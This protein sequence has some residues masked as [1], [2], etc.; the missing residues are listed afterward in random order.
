MSEHFVITADHG[1]LRIFQ[2][3]EAP[4]QSTAAL[5]EIQAE[6]FPA[7][8]RGYVQRDTDM[9]G[10]FQSSAHQGRGPGAPTARQGMSV[11]ERLPM[12]REEERRQ[13]RDLA[14]GIEQFLSQHPTA[15]WDFAAGPEIHHAVLEALSPAVRGRLGK[16]V[17]KDLVHQP[18]ADLIGHFAGR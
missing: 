12:Q 15:T 10:R 8:L 11:D 3:R 4:E 9:A 18:A 2:Q 7:G 6:D 13:L 1:H 17:T 16:T 14:A 5:D